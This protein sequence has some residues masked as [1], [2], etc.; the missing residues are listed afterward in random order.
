MSQSISD[1]HPAVVLRSHYNHMRALL[2]AAT[3]ALVVL[4]GTVAI[5]AVDSNGDGSSTAAAAQQATPPPVS[6]NYRNYPDE[7]TRGPAAT[8]HSINGR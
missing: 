7:G 6:S 5:L 3:V 8:P 2:V 4:A 1:Q